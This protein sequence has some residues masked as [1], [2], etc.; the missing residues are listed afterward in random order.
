MSSS[1]LLEQA[2]VVRGFNREPLTHNTLVR[3][4]KVRV[5]PTVLFF[6]ADGKEVAAHPM[7]SLLARAPLDLRVNTLKADRDTIELPAEAEP[8][9]APNG[10]RLAAAAF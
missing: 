9:A 1:H 6:G 2:D 5:A 10:L 8:I 3:L 7:A 4:W